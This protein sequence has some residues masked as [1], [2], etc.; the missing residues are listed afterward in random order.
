MAGN[1]AEQKAK[2][3]RAVHAAFAYSAT[4]QDASLDTPVPVTV[5]W[6]NKLVIMGDFQESG[7]ANVVEGIE[8]IIFNREE[9]ELVEYQNNGVDLQGLEIRPR[10]WVVITDPGFENTKLVMAVREPHVGPIEEKWQV[11]R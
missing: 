7:Y 10:G 8:R 6:H 9:L 1:F 5:R 3:R 4:Y 11:T 2:A